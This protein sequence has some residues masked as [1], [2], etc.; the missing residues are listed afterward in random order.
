[1]P[2]IAEINREEPDGKSACSAAVGY[3]DSVI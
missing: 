3:F 2:L 1:V